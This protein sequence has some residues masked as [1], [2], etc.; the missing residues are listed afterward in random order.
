[1][2]GKGRITFVKMGYSGVEV[3]GRTRGRYCISLGDGR[4]VVLEKRDEIH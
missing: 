3:K 1:M 4:N 2:V